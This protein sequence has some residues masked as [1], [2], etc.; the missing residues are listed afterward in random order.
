MSAPEIFTPA[1]YEQMRA[2]EAHGWWN[3]AMRDIAAMLLSE[4]RLPAAGVMLDVGC[5]S[6]QTMH[7]FRRRHRG[8]RTIGLDVAP[9]GLEAARLAGE[10]GLLRASALELPLRDASADG[11][12]TLDVLQH[13]PLDGGD[14]SALR[15]CRR[16]LR[17]GGFLLVRTNA[18][19]FPRAAD[20]RAKNFH[21]YEPAELR[22]RLEAAGFE[23]SRLGRVNALLGLAEIP[24]ELR[25]SRRRGGAGY[26]GILADAG[27]PGVGAKLKR[28][29]LRQEGRLLR[30]GISLPL[31][32]TIVA[33]CRT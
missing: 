10:A 12:I 2:L 17:P 30:A 25:A 21:K 7:W 32:R 22:G 18:Q 23:V 3:A 29:W 15:E 14:V 9:E 11:I 27:R 13:L 28:A 24:R 31:G 6:G 26:H 1:Y 33:L 5:G 16:V 20:D 19:A 8:W 4:L